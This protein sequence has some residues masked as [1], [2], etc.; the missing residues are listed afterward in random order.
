MT[1]AGKLGWGLIGAS[2]IACRFMI[3][4]IRWQPDSE[5]VAVASRSAERAATFAQANGISRH[6]SSVEA[7]LADPGVDAVYVS[8]DNRLHREH[9]LAA[10]AAGKPVLCEKPLALTVEDAVAMVE[11]CRKAGVVIGTNHH[12]RTAPTIVEIRRLLEGGAIGRPL[13]ARVA[14]ITQLPE[15][16]R[17]WRVHDPGA[18]GGPLNDMG[19]HDFDALRFVL[20]QEVG[21]VAAQTTFQGFAEVVEDQVMATLRFEDGLL[22]GFHAAYNLGFGG[23][24][25]DVH[26]S[27]G[28][29]LGHSALTATGGGQVVVRTAAGERTVDLGLPRIAYEG[30]VAAF[31]AAVRDG[32][33]PAAT[34]LDGLRSL[35]IAVA[36]RESARE[37]RAVKVQRVL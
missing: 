16:L 37:G 23:N 35:E 34:G 4:A 28:S 9:T 1:P 8:S 14:H 26:G 32:G 13:A 17:T 7:L 2:D 18:G 24:S 22:A 3:A 19:T 5:P 15:H 11:A 25:L 10:A 27:G 21:E 12:L 20:G 36:V 6:Y 33:A 29:I 30:T 31:N